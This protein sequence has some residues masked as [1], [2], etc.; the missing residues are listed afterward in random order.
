[1][2]L[3]MFFLFGFARWTKC[4]WWAVENNYLN[5][6]KLFEFAVEWIPA[7]RNKPK[8]SWFQKISCITAITD[9]KMIS[10]FCTS[11][12]LCSP[13]QSAVQIK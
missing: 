5:I 3:G 8:L 2:M 6:Y 9:K 4:I 11:A 13:P 7:I 1:M 12:I 10:V